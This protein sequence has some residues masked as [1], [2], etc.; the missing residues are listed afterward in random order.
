MAGVVGWVAGLGR[1]PRLRPQSTVDRA[2]LRL[3]LP[4][5]LA[6]AH[7]K[8]DRDFKQCSSPAEGGTL[9]LSKHGFPTAL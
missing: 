4:A 2:K 6:A 5:Q 9:Q 8:R 1:S 7:A 3:R